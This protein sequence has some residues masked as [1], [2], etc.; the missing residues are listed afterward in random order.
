MCHFLLAC[1]EDVASFLNRLKLKVQ[2]YI[3]LMAY[4]AVE[5]QSG[6]RGNILVRGPYVLRC[7]A[8]ADPWAS[9]LMRFGLIY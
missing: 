2:P 8:A 3:V 4:R 1:Y 5:R 7:G 9:G 6:P